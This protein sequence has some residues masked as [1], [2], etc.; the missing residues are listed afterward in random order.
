MIDT[1]TDIKMIDTYT[2]IKMIDTYIDIKIIDTYT[3]IKIIDTYTD[4]R[5]NS[6]TNSADILSIIPKFRRSHRRNDSL[7]GACS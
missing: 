4:I 7:F 6:E 1:Y 5:Q 3:D 2:D